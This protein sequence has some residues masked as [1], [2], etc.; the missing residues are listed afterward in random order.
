MEESLVTPNQRAVM[1]TER[2]NNEKEADYNN[3]IT[4]SFLT[5]RTFKQELKRI[6]YIAGAIIPVLSSEFLLQV[7]SII[8]VG[9]LG[10][11]SL[12]S[13]SLAIS[14]CGVTGFSFLVSFSFISTSLLSI[15][16]LTI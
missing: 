9:H 11:L 8:M 1:K 12:S 5:W 13:S 2:N 10:E 16:I 15:L 4:R 6:G 7:V 14:L 3:D